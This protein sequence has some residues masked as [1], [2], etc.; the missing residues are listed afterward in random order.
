MSN[1]RYCYVTVLTNDRYLDG[2][3]TLALSIKKNKCK[4]PLQVIIPKDKKALKEQLNKNKIS[5]I[6]MDNVVENTKEYIANDVS[7]WAETLFKLNIFRLTQYEKIVFLDS[8]MIIRKNIDKLFECPHMS[9]S[10]AGKCIHPEW[11]GLNSGLMVIKPEIKD[12]E[13]MITAIPDALR[14]VMKNGR[15]FGDQDV[16]NYVYPDWSTHKELILSETF[17]AM[18]G[19]GKTSYLKEIEKQGEIKILHFIGHNKPWNYPL[20]SYIRYLTR[21]IIRKDF[22]ELRYLK[23]Y[24]KMIREARRNKIKDC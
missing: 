15:G 11:E 23:E 12:Y 10:I 22:S 20:I 4:Y 6:C 17:N 8:D 1:N 14:Y 13:R 16:I 7:Y 5:Y 24:K 3:I 2:T 19:L 9:A 18:F 21:L